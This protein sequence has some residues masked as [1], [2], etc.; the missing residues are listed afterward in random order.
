[1]TPHRIILWDIDGTLLHSGGAGEAAIIRTVRALYGKELALPE[2][3]YRGRT[4][5]L[6]VRQIFT[7]FG[8]SWSEESVARFRNTYLDYLREEI[9]HASGH[10]FP[11]VERMLSSI[12]EIAGWQQGLL[13]GNFERG[14][15]IKLDHFGLGRFFGFGA[16]GDRWE[17]RNEVARAAFDLV[18]ERWGESL[19]AQ[20]IFLIGD[21]PH[22]VLCAQAIG[23]CSIA[24]ATGGYSLSE[25]A[26][27]RPTLLLPD[28]EQFGP[29]LSLVKGHG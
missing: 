17:C 21:T 20:Q 6:I 14:A 22:D 7:R 8:I 28:L 23:A 25:L 10:L 18:R 9:S 5:L 19:S 2:I 1:M 24:V 4:D 15:R 13:T 12:A 11:G 3:D 16:F 26:G 27:Y 29:V